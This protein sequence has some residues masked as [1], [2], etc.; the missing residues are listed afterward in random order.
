MPP[1]LVHDAVNNR[2]AHARPFPGFL[3]GKERFEHASLNVDRN[4][5]TGIGDGKLHESAV[6][7]LTTR[8]AAETFGTVPLGEFNE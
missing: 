5:R 2:Q 7:G 6:E 1:V 8:G 3:G 4:A